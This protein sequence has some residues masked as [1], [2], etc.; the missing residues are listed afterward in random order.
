MAGDN[1]GVLLR[2]VNRDEIERGQVIAKPKTIV[3]H[4]T[5]KAAIYVL[6]K[7]KVDVTHHSSLTTNLNFTSEQLT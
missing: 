4:T 7:K 5:F 6:K 2:G 3:P 1:A